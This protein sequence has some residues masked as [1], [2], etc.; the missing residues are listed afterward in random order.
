MRYARIAAWLGGKSCG[1]PR[2]GS[3]RARKPLRR[4]ALAGAV[5]GLLLAALMG[6]VASGHTSN[7]G[8]SSLAPDSEDPAIQ[9]AAAD[10]YMAEYGVSEDVAEGRLRIQD[11]AQSVLGSVVQDIGSKWAGSWNFMTFPAPRDVSKSLSAYL[12]TP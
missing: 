8:S 2:R 9:A 7:S 12:P 4:V 10:Y 3:R 11:D 1:S 6:G 5:G